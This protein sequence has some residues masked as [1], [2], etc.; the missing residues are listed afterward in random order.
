MASEGGKEL[1]KS[2]GEKAR[3]GNLKTGGVNNKRK[4]TEVLNA[5][6][7]RTDGSEA[8]DVQIVDSHSV[9]KV[10]RKMTAQELRC[11]LEG[12]RDKI[13]GKLEAKSETIEGPVQGR[14][15]VGKM[16]ACLIKD[17]PGEGPGVWRLGL[18]LLGPDKESP[19]SAGVS[20]LATVNIYS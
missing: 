15:D 9:S 10:R 19:Q 20:F 5:Q 7:Q 13:R 12:V 4:L 18:D 3:S 2:S 14:A 6:A 1:K 17:I 11:K 16:L 8:E